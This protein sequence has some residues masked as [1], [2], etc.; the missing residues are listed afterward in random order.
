REGA[1]RDVLVGYE[2]LAAEESGLRA[3]PRDALLG[4]ESLRRAAGLR[5]HVADAVDPRLRRQLELCVRRS[6]ARDLR[7]EHMRLD[8]ERR[9]VRRELERPLDATPAA[10]R[11]V[12]CHEQDLQRG[13]GGTRKATN[14]SSSKTGFKPSRS[15]A[16]TGP[17]RVRTSHCARHACGSSRLGCVKNLSTARL[18]FASSFGCVFAAWVGGTATT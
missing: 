12:A 16:C 11:E 1:P 10:R 18:R 6:R 13:P 8:A 17:A 7:R 3:E 2:E 15:I 14:L 5:P 9:Q 4:E